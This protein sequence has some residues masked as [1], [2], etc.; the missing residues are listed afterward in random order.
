ME[1]ATQKKVNTLQSIYSF[2]N[3]CKTKL[4]GI[5]YSLRAS[6]NIVSSYLL[7][8]DQKNVRLISS[9]FKMIDLMEMG[10]TA[11]EKLELKRKPF[12]KMQAMYLLTPTEATIDLLIQ[13]F[14]KKKT[15]QYGTVHLF[16]SSK[17]PEH[18]FQK[19][20]LCQELM[21]WY[22]IKKFKIFS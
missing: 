17:L 4:K 15:P 19:L 10:V 7:V 13:D 18:L 6:S 2:K 22:F 14:H 1:E 16:F 12:P 20:A 21:S 11:L 9:Y 8:L 3:F 5:F